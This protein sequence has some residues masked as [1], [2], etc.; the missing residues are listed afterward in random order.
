MRNP[1]LVLGVFTAFISAVHKV[2]AC[3]KDIAEPYTGALQIESKYVQ[4]DKSKSTLKEG[5][6]ADSK[7]VKEQIQSYGKQVVAFSDYMIRANGEAQKAAQSCLEQAL[8]DWAE[9]GALLSGDVSKTGMA[10]RK[11]T[12]A[13]IA[14]AVYKLQALNIGDFSLT[15]RQRAWL[16]KLADKVV[17]DY[18]ERLSPDFRYFNNHDY[19][20]AWAVVANALATGNTAHINYAYAVLDRAA[21]QLEVDKQRNVGWLPNE[22]GRGKLAMNYMHYALSPLVMLNN[23]A[24]K[25]S[26]A[27]NKSEKAVILMVN[28]ISGFADNPGAFSDIV[29]GPQEPVPAYKAAWLIPY[30]HRY[31]KDKAAMQLYDRYDQDVDGYSQLGGLLEPLYPL[32]P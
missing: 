12:L 7:A 18:K 1:L 27:S 5:I 10:M 20:A 2:Q 3:P 32:N 9:A 29:S 22:V 31:P 16:D 8:T 15:E 26:L 21:A 28:F 4:T 25:F 14:M 17:D 13:S 23:Y 24:E 6:G 19:W 30:L 11:W